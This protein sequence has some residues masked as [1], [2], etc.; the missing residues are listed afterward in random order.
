VLGR[1]GGQVSRA[2][3]IVGRLAALN[4]RRGCGMGQRLAAAATTWEG[5]GRGEAAAGAV[6]FPA[7][8]PRAGRAIRSRAISFSGDDNI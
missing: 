8:K 6:F 2:E 5:W 1:G 7:G 4:Q 3:G